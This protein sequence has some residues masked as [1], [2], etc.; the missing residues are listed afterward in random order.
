MV[1]K[2]ERAFNPMV[3]D[4]MNEH[5]HYILFINIFINSECYFWVFKLMAK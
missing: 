2:Q 3:Y 1:M 4:Y 5:N